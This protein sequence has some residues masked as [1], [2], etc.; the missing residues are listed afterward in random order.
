M[1]GLCHK[2]IPKEIVPR[3]IKIFEEIKRCIKFTL[4]PKII[5]I[6]EKKHTIKV[7]TDKSPNLS[8]NKKIYKIMKIEIITNKSFIHFFLIYVSKIFPQKI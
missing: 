6:I 4:S 2:Y 1:I 3:K 8:A 5:I 7:Y